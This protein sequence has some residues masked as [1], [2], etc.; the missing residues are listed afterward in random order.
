[1]LSSLNS[2]ILRL[3]SFRPITIYSGGS[4]SSGCGWKV[5]F[6]PQG[7]LIHY[8]GQSVRQNILAGLVAYRQS[9]IHF[10]RKHY[11]RGGDY[12]VRGLLF[13]KFGVIG[14]K[15]L[16]EFGFMKLLGRDAQPAYAKMLLSK[17]VYGMIF[18]RNRVRPVE[19]VLT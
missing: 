16:A 2:R 5:I 12:L 7:K 1:M 3:T 13:L 15:A 10:A 11:G 17:K 4:R 14:L 6:C 9:Q 8:S 18:R 19:P